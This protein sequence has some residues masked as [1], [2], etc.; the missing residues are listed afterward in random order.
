MPNFERL[1]L[2]K[3]IE[4]M[5]ILLGDFRDIIIF[6][7]PSDTSQNG[8][9]NRQP[10][11]TRKGCG[12]IYFLEESVALKFPQSK[13]IPFLILSDWSYNWNVWFIYVVSHNSNYRQREV[14]FMLC[15]GAPL[16]AYSVEVRPGDKSI[17]GHRTLGATTALSEF[18][19]SYKCFMDSSS[20]VLV[21]C[22]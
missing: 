11:W 17:E 1:L 7:I 13:I 9:E 21:W 5:G 2:P 19:E 16:A 4:W 20:S 8:S 18:N 3:K 14:T 15:F 22:K 12:L 10:L 6:F